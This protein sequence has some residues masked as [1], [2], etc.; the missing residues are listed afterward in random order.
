[1]MN[2]MLGVLVSATLLSAFAACI[3]TTEESGTQGA[4]LGVRVTGVGST[5]NAIQSETATNVASF[6]NSSIVTVA[7]NDKTSTSS[8]VVYT[9]TTRTIYRGATLMGFSYSKDGGVTWTHGTKVPTPAG[10]SAL[11]GDPGLTGSLTNHNYVFLSNLAMPDALFPG[12]ST[13]ADN[14]EPLL[15]GACIARS[16]DGGISFSN[17]QCVNNSL[18]FYEIYSAYVDVTASQIDVY[19][20][21]T[22]TKPFGLLPAPFPG[23]SISTHPRLRVD[24]VNN[25]LYAAAVDSK[26]NL[27]MNSFDGTRWGRAITVSRSVNFSGTAE[28]YPV[29][30]MSGLNPLRTGPQFSFDVGTASVRGDDAVRVLYTSRDST[31]NTLYVRGSVCKRDLSGCTDAPEY[32]TTPGVVYHLG[33]QFNPVVRAVPSVFGSP[34]VWMSSWSS[35]E[36]DPSGHTVSVERAA[37]QVDSGGHRFEVVFDAVAGQTPCMDND[38]KG[39]YWADYDDLQVLKLD[40]AGYPTWIRT[41]PDSTINGEGKCSYR[42]LYTGAPINT[43]SVTF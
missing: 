26:M 31:S 9:A 15:G 37:M 6:T 11:W 2:R 20:A 3:S 30:P 28:W 39:G 1:M 29:I 16:S 4:A 34:A 42:W 38:P 22:E 10:I 14:L 43:S 27:R 5:A 19:R 40:G 35:R 32:G 33:D 7:Y 25:V 17:Y 24:T 13:T 18:H 8:S 21:L 36:H 23:E 12:A 41:F